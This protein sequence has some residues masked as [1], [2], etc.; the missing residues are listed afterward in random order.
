MRSNTATIPELVLLCRTRPPPP[1]AAVVVPLTVPPT[2]RPPA[3]PALDALLPMVDHRLLLA[4]ASPAVG[5]AAAAICR[6]AKGSVV[7]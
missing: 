6:P 2:L 4:S 5:R 1:C 7:P 3:L